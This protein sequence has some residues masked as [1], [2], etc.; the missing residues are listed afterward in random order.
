MYT[1]LTRDYYGNS[2]FYNFGYW[3]DD[4]NSAKDAAENLVDKL[5]SLAP[6][7]QGPILD[8]ACGMGATTRHLARSFDPSDVVGINISEKQLKTATANAPRSH[9]AA[10]DAAKLAFPDSSFGTVICV[11]AA[12]HFKTRE[13]FVLEAH[14][15][16]KSGGS[17]VLSDILVHRKPLGI[18]KKSG[19]PENLVDNLADYKAVFQ[20]AGYKNI[21]VI[22]AT[23]ACWKSF[24]RHMRRWGWAKLRS[25]EMSI[26]AY[27]AGSAVWT[28]VDFSTKNYLL[29]S[30]TKD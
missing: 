6:S 8:V 3:L 5:L 17:L 2:D 27:L 29:V 12:F 19:V 16:L 23:E 20:R 10:M 4:T 7:R 1:S 21:E 30:A 25:G 9:F 15:V 18:G 28:L 26:P 14:R 24:H 22:D 11:E 13:R